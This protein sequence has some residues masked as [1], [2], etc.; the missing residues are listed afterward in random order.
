MTHEHLDGERRG[1]EGWA[2]ARSAALRAGV[3]PHSKGLEQPDTCRAAAP[4]L[5]DIYLLISAPTVGFFDPSVL[6]GCL[7]FLEEQPDFPKLN[8]TSEEKACPY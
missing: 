6:P 2:E 4:A 7:A 1:A 3:C 8:T 5:R